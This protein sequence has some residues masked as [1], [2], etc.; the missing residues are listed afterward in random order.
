M[1]VGHLRDVWPR[2]S[3]PGIA[4]WERAFPQSALVRAVPGSADAWLIT[5]I[6]ASTGR[7]VIVCVEGAKRAEVLAEE[8]RTFLGDDDVRLYPS[9]DAVPYNMKSPFGPTTESRLAVLL[10]LLGGTAK[11]IIA[12]HAALMQRVPAPNDLFNHTVRLRAGAELPIDHLALWLQDIGFR[13]ETRVENVGTFAVRGG[14]VDIYPYNSPHPLRCEFFGDTLEQIRHFSV[15]SQKSLGA[16]AGV[17][18]APMKELCLSASQVVEGARRMLW[19][20]KEHGADLQALHTLEHQWCHAAD[21]EGLEW[22]A[23]WFEHRTA[24]ILDYLPDSAVL[25][26]DD[27]QSPQVRFDETVE[28]YRRHL[29]RVPAP[30]R[31]AVSPPEDLLETPQAL[32]EGMSL[33]PCVYVDTLGGPEVETTVAADLREQPSL[34]PR[35]ELLADSLRQQHESG[36]EVIVVSPTVGHAE[37]L[38]E[39]LGDKAPFVRVV[40]GVLHEGFLDRTGS[41]VVYTDTQLFPRQAQAGRPRRYKGGEALA[42]YDDLMPG[43]FVVHVDHGIAQFVGI[44]RVQA[45]GGA[46]DCMVLSY[47]EKSRLY[48][49]LD[50]FQRVQKYVGREG[51]APALSKLGSGIW[52]RTKERTRES[53]KQMAGELVELYA[54]RQFL[55]GIACPPDTVWQ[56]EFEDAF[57]Y[58]ETQDQDKAITDVKKDMESARPMDRLVCGDV[59]FGKT[60]VAMRAAFK[61][62]MSGYQV[63]ILAPTTILVAQHYETMK[64]RMASFPVRVGQLSRFLKPRE[65]KDVVAKLREGQVDILVGT[66]RALSKDVSFKNL[67][68]L[69]VDEEQRFGVKHKERLKQYRFEVDVLSMTATPIPRTLHMSLIGA[70]DLS[71]I[72]TPPRDRLPIETRVSEYHDDLLKQAIDEELERGGQVYLVDNRITHLYRLLERV[73]H[74]VPRARAVVAHGQMN[75]EEL[76]RIMKEFVAGRFDVLIATTIIENGLDIPN[77][78]TIV[79]N[80]AD[81]LG[82]SQLYQLRGRVGRS[83]EQAFAYLLVPSFKGVTDIALKRLRALEQF[84]DLGSGFQI[85]M[86]DLEIRGAGNILGEVQSGSIVAVGFETYCRLLKEAIDEIQGRQ[87]TMDEV[88][89]KVDAEVDA[90]LPTDY[91]PDAPTRVSLYRVLSG[92]KNAEEIEQMR[93]ELVDRFGPLPPS[94]VNLLLI[95]EIKAAARPLRCE[96]VS[97][98]RDGSLS[99]FVGGSDE[100]VRDV[101]GRII[102]RGGGRFDVLYEKPVRARTRLSSAS[103]DERLREALAIVREI[104]G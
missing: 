67:G 68:L 6:R 97:V 15:F 93:Q 56:K 19:W 13:R 38:S 66:H 76:A 32:L 18:I 31:S 16:V 69:I 70:R 82:L 49:P 33:R 81:L 1:Q 47:A 59:G 39:L 71:V 102:E 40:L 78:N 44:E 12:P 94:V 8:C 80:R 2:R 26:W 91:V 9:R 51:V 92:A 23:Q 11:V 90:Y 24:T 86:R 74:L 64:E 103:A 50:D 101:L 52:E 41:R 88:P 96:R 95:I 54:K 5:D 3:F 25:L 37:R 48:V 72:M 63:A 83:S 7:P 42:S 17:E 75:E 20:G 87:K 57:L 89:A 45:G 43:D 79:I 60:E 34:A 28:N 98:G 30:I 85:A 10:M 62:V 36:L 65:Q 104:T 53:L 84:T 29:E 100:T 61:A 46:Q 73:E 14:L 99:L 35:L 55:A 27:L 22:F 77:V 21:H 4:G 58:E